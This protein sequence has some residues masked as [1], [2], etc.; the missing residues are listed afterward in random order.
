MLWDLPALHRAWQRP[1]R[2]GPL[3]TV[4]SAPAEC[5]LIW[6]TMSAE[7]WGAPHSTQQGY[8]AAAES[9]WASAFT[10]CCSN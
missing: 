10:A 7:C 3:P 9:S 6:L 8:Q 5:P 4:P 2:P 1:Q